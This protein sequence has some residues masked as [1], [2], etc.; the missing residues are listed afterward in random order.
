[1][2]RRR[3]CAYSGGESVIWSARTPVDVLDVEGMSA[4]LVEESLARPE[5]QQLG[6]RTTLWHGAL[7]LQERPAD[8]PL[9]PEVGHPSRKRIVLRDVA[10]HA[11]PLS[12]WRRPG[13]PEADISIGP[14]GLRWSARIHP[15]RRLGVHSSTVGAPHITRP[16]AP[17]VALS[18]IARMCR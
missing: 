9:C 16:I 2:C 13:R 6:L 4:S 3:A 5:I 14:R 12:T 15:D 7:G 18:G 11:C 1:M 10:Q 8:P 17:A